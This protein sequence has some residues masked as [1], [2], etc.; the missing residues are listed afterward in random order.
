LRL[1]INSQISGEYLSIPPSEGLTLLL[2]LT[3]ILHITFQDDGLIQR[4]RKLL[5]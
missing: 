5:T 3:V 2:Q 4:L 1:G